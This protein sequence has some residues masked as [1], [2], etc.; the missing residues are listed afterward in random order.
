MNAKNNP[1]ET[2]S[3][4]KIIDLNIPD[5]QAPVKPS[6]SDNLI[7]FHNI[8]VELPAEEYKIAMS[9]ICQYCTDGTIPAL[10]GLIK[11][12]VLLAI[13]RIAAQQSAPRKRGGQIGNQN[14]R[15]TDSTN[16]S[17]NKKSNRNESKS[18]RNESKC[19]TGVP[20]DTP[21][22]APVAS[23]AIP[24][25]PVAVLPPNLNLNLNNNINFKYLN[26][27]N[28]EN[29]SENERRIR[30]KNNLRRFGFTI[31]DKTVSKIIEAVPDIMWLTQGYDF[32][33]Y[34]AQYVTDAYSSKGKTKL[35]L[36]KLFIS[37]LNPVK[38]ETPWKAYPNWLSEQ[39][40]RILVDKEALIRKTP[41][42]KTCPDC[43]ENVRLEGLRCPNCGGFY[44]W[45]DTNKRHEFVHHLPLD[46]EG[47]WNRIME[48]RAKK[49]QE[50]SN[51]NPV[52]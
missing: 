23:T 29:E 2:G 18:N 49:Q 42:Q 38:W 50:A 14:A 39:M 13:D 9:A 11:A 44:E 41:P 22:P 28:C 37:A 31:A 51:A 27:L 8:L 5:D 20:V 3:R 21:I 25:S 24:S 52:Q 35:E 40:E 46:F 17:E 33:S 1:A 32:P 6:N 47:T 43:G 30:I 45:S 4:I 12:V 7:F 34:L 48:L 16:D 26:Y 15:K 19:T 36:Q 10:T